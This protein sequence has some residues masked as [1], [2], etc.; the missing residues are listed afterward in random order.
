L[1]SRNHIRLF[2]AATCVWAVFLI[3]GLPSYYQQYSKLSMVLFDIVGLDIQVN[4]ARG[5]DD[6]FP[7]AFDHS[8][9]TR[10]LG[11]QAGDHSVVWH[12]TNFSAQT[13]Y[14]HRGLF[15][16]LDVLVS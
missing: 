12:S 10:G 7:A 4:S 2:L 11:Q 6:R 8:K 13:R 9:P 3:G 15:S 16:I 5:T 1:K 14:K